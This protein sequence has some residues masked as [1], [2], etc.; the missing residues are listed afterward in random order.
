M[1]TF[2][3]NHWTNKVAHRNRRLIE[4]P[5]TPPPS[6]PHRDLSDFIARDRIIIQLISRDGDKCYLCGRTRN[7]DYEVEHIIPRSLNG[8]DHLS[9]L[10]LAR[11]GLYL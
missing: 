2:R 6:E 7:G 3:R 4:Q 8:S 10:G 5:I 9:N 11:E 1:A